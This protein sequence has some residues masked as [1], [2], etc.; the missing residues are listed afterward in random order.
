MKYRMEIDVSFPDKKDAEDL[1]NYI[2][3]I[4]AKTYKPKGDEKIPVIQNCR[5]HLC[6][7]EEAN[8][9]PC[10][11]YVNVDFNAA[12]KIHKL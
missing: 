12:Q 11:D 7:H 4:K 1:L 9:V 5:Y 6:T 10:K 2:E 8:P 3:S